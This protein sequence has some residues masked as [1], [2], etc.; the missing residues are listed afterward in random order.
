MPTVTGTLTDIGLGSLGPS[1]P[2]LQF[3]P[4]EPAVDTAGR[5]FA[6][7]AVEVVPAAQGSFT[8]NLASTDGL[9]PE[10]AHWVMSIGW[11]NPDGYMS[12]DGYFVKDFPTWRIRVPVEGGRL[13]DLLDAKPAANVTSV[14]LLTAAE[15]ERLSALG[16]QWVF[17]LSTNPAALYRLND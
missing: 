12:S 6:S 13:V 8:V 15:D 1:N 17:E 9:M 3:T 10:R 2:V 4:S 7:R 5:I 11:R 14:G 16:V